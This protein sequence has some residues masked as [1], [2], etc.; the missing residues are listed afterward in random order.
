VRPTQRVAQE[1]GVHL[2]RMGDAADEIALD[3]LD[4]L[5][6]HVELPV[7]RGEVLQRLLA[8]GSGEGAQEGDDVG[9]G[10][11]EVGHVAGGDALQHRHLARGRSHR[12]QLLR[13]DERVDPGQQ[14]VDVVEHLHRRSRG[15]LRAQLPHAVAGSLV[16]GED[17]FE[18]LAG[19][20]GDA[21]VDHGTLGRS[22]PRTVHGHADPAEG[23]GADADRG[24]EGQHGPAEAGAEH[25]QQGREASQT[26]EDDGSAEPH[27]PG[28]TR[29]RH[30]AG[31]GA[32]DRALERSLL[33][34]P[35]VAPLRGRLPRQVLG[36]G[37]DRPVG[38]RVGGSCIGRRGG[39]VERRRRGADRRDRCWWAEPLVAGSG[40]DGRVGDLRAGLLGR[41]AGLL[42]R[43]AR[44]AG[45]RGR[46]VGRE[47]V[48]EPAAPAARLLGRGCLSCAHCDSLSSPGR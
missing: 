39:R 17:P 4:A 34:A 5:A 23:D 37:G 16:G 27:Q 48:R 32:A 10:V 44:L 21:R 6:E 30:L 14:R 1:L 7:D 35:Q 20:A 22:C 26:A 41:R 8:S 36:A 2:E 9:G 12:L 18:H 15:G 31:G 28:G 33:R 19:A 11:D 29:R 24:A 40:A 3:P 38:R 43:R 13:A 25:D 47:G 46:R 45:L 42:R